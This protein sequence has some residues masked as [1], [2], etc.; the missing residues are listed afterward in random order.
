[1]PDTITITG[2]VGTIP[3][4]FVTRDNLAVTSFRLASGQRRYD[5]GA[6]AWVDGETNWYSVTAFRQLATNVSRS[7]MKGDHIVVSGRVRVRDWTA[8]ERSGTSVDI[9]AD[10]V[11]HDLRW[12]TSSFTRVMTPGGTAGHGGEAGGDPDGISSGS[13]SAGGSGSGPSHSDP[14][15]GWGTPGV[16]FSSA[17]ILEAVA[18]DGYQGPPVE[19]D[20]SA[21]LDPADA[22][23][24]D[25]KEDVPF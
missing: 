11:G 21:D 16:G 22:P 8:G 3:R 2:V 23:W 7:I 13:D 15:D 9:E 1:M 4:N 24:S 5:R 20:A 14:S 18:A 10:A 19:D 17:G 25:E 12:G 6:G